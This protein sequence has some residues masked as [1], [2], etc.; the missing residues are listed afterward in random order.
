MKSTE[1]SDKNKKEMKK[2][3]TAAKDARVSKLNRFLPNYF[4]VFDIMPQRVEFV[5]KGFLLKS[6]SGKLS[7][8]ASIKKFE[9]SSAGR[10]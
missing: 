4:R 3:D 8:K 1:P 2:D 10:T 5:P 7:R 9:E 6:T